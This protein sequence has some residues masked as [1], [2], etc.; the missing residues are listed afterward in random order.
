ME[1]PRAKAATEAAV[2]CFVVDI[3]EFEEA[4]VV[5]RFAGEG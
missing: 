4:G 3:E 2:I 1:L 5:F